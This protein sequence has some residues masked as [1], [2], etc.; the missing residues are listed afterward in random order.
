M[1]QDTALQAAALLSDDV[2]R[3][4]YSFVRRQGHPVTRE[5]AA[6]AVRISAKL[7][8]F[9]LDKLVE[10]G[11]LVADYRIPHGLARRVGRAP[12]RYLPSSLEISLSLPERRYDL[13]AEI[14]LDALA[15]A[16][17]GQAPHQVARRVAS[18]RGRHLGA[19]ERSTRRLGRPGPERTVAVAQDLL[20]GH[21]FEPASDDRGVLVLRNCPFQA[22]AKR[23]PELV[24]GLNVAFVDGLLRGLG[25]DT[26][27]AD[28]APEEGLCCVRVRPPL[29]AR[30]AVS[31]S[32]PR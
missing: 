5:E 4:L 10:G 22:L 7:A 18:E 31:S 21:G 14:L 23:A 3:S 9:H 20:D 26:V 17:A 29:A 11:L 25:N 24:C 8:A 2:R 19:E 6:K 28:L 30:V 16:G 27:V 12:K 32:G 13:M 15:G 1:E